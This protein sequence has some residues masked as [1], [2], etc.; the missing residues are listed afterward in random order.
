VD[1]I[2]IRNLK[3]QCV[4]GVWEWE[5]RCKQTLYLDLEMAGDVQRAAA[6]D[7]LEDAL[8]YKAISRRVTALLQDSRFKLV[9][10]LAEAT[11]RTLQEEFHIP[12]LRLRVNKRGALRNAGDVGVVIERGAPP[13]GVPAGP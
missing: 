4:I 6:S 12:W 3:V 5:R 8:D 10:T 1:I 7:A 13:P 11:A 9:E 2:Y